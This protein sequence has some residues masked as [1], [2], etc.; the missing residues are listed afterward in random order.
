MPRR[1]DLYLQQNFAVDYGHP[2]LTA[3]ETNDIYTVPSGRSAVIDRVLY[4]NPTGLA[5]SDTNYVVI[6]AICNGQV[7]ASWSTKL[8]G[9][10]GALVA[11]TQVAP[12]VSGTAANINAAAGQKIQ[13]EVTVTGTP[14]LPAGAIRVEGRLL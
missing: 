3:N 9:G 12:T 14:T 8:T 2:S 4:V 5:T 10:D 7:A 6:S 13:F 11:G 1:Q